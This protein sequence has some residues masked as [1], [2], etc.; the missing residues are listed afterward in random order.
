[1]IT[2]RKVNLGIAAAGVLASTRGFAQARP[3]E[4]KISHYNPPNHT[5][6]K[7]LVAWGEQ[8]EKLSNGRLKTTIYPAGQLGGG[9]NRQFDSCRN[10]VVDIALSI[11]GA[12]PGR[13]STTELVTLPFVSPSEGASSAVCGKRL[14]AL[15]PTYL[16]QEHQGLKILWMATIPPLKFHSRVPLRTIADFKGLKIRYAG[17]QYKNIIEA[18]G[19]VPLPVPPPETQDALAKGIID[20]A[21]FAYEGAASFGLDSVVKY[22]LE[23]GVS[24]L[25]WGVVMNPAKYDSLPADLKA[26]IDKTTTPDDA[27]KFGA[28]FDAAELAGKRQLVSKGV[29]VIELAPA[30]LATMKKLLAPQIDVAIAEVEKQGRPGRKFYEAYTK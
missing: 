28:D 19:G 14:S 18:L 4:L 26:L 3:I 11:H 1:M 30:E 16:A 7:Y 15:A 22:S 24:S 20:A 6:Q 10:G 12:T 5:C 23:P 27:E 13:Y 29:Q 17:V 8:L 25:T 9:A 2:R 21:V